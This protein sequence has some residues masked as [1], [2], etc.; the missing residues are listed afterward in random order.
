MK[1][2]VTDFFCM[3]QPLHCSVDA[4]GIEHWMRPQVEAFNLKMLDRFARV[5]M[6]KVLFV[7]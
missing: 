6:L 1:H 5:D 4:V 3:E 7:Q 2:K